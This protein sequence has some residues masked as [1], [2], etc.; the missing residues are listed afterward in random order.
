[1]APTIKK[2]GLI[3]I[4]A[5]NAVCIPVP[6]LVIKFQAFCALTTRLIYVCQAL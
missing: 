5:L 1:M 3:D 4:T 6:I 2:I